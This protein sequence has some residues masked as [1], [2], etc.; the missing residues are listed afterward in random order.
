MEPV[1]KKLKLKDFCVPKVLYRN[2]Y[3]NQENFSALICGSEDPRNYERY[4]Y[5]V[6]EVKLPSFEVKSFPHVKKHRWQFNLVSVNS[7]LLAIGDEKFIDCFGSDFMTVE[8]FSHSSK[9]WRLQYVKFDNRCCYCACFFMSKLYVIGGFLSINGDLL[10]SCFANNLNSVRSS[11]LSDLNVA[12]Y[13]AAC[14]IFE[15][16]IVV[17]GGRDEDYDLKSVEAYDY[18]ENKRTYLPDMVEER[19]QHA[20]VSMGCK[21]FVIG[22][23]CTTSCEVFNSFSRKFTTLK[24]ASNLSSLA[25]MSTIATCIGDSVLVIHHPFENTINPYNGRPTVQLYDATED[26]W[27]TVNS[28]FCKDF[29]NPACVRYNKQ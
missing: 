12:R 14:T 19:S 7:G 5:Q 21:I 20:V 13:D 23:N 15:S 26:S 4:N 28:D 25:I 10:G 8:I 2:R 22:G 11:K 24:S 18:Y 27:S 29:F 16:R 1:A 9:M 3:C 6:L 17:T